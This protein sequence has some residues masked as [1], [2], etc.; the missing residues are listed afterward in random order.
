M[1][2]LNDVF[3]SDRLSGADGERGF[4]EPWEVQVFALTRALIA[5]GVFSESEWA[6]TFGALLHQPDARD[7]AGDYYARFVAALEELL[8]RKAIADPEHVQ[9]LTEAWHRA[10]EAT[11]HGKPIELANDPHSSS[12]VR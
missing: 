2:T 10:A 4:S 3:G 11:P 7:D 12:A 5:N 1:T 9:A 8:G 6:E